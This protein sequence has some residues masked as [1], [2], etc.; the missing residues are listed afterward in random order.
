MPCYCRN[1]DWSAWHLNLTGNMGKYQAGKLGIVED[2]DG[3]PSSCENKTLMLP[4]K[5][6]T[7]EWSG[8]W[9]LGA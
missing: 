2:N 1:V 9:D 6:W 5:G 8:W 7:W 3:G 4:K